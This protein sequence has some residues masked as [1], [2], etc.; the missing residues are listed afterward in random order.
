MEILNQLQSDE[1]HSFEIEKNSVHDENVR[2]ILS[3]F[4]FY[5]FINIIQTRMK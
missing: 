1:I 5:H 4:I 2:K 3:L